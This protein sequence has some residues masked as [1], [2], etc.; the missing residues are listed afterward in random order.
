MIRNDL[1]EKLG[2]DWRSKFSHRD[3]DQANYEFG[4]FE[5]DGKKINLVLNPK[6]L[7]IMDYYYD[8]FSGKI[9]INEFIKTEKSKYE[10]KYTKYFIDKDYNIFT[11]DSRKNTINKRNLLNIKRHIRNSYAQLTIIT[12]SETSSDDR[13]ITNVLVHRIIANMFVP[14][15]D[16]EHFNIVNHK[17][18]NGDD[19]RKENLEWCSYSYNNSAENKQEITPRCYYLRSDGE[20]FDRKKLLDNNLCVRDVVYS[21]K[22]GRKY[23]GYTWSRVVPTLNNYLEKHPVVVDGWYEDNGL[24]DF[25]SHKVRANLCGILEID[26]I[27]NIGTLNKKTLIY[28]ITINKKHYF[29]HRL[30][31]EIISGK[32]IDKN[33]VIDHLIP[34]T[35]DN[36]DNSFYNL[37]EKTQSENMRNPLTQLLTKKYFNIDQYNIFGKLENSYRSITIEFIKNILEDNPSKFIKSLEKGCPQ[38]KNKIYLDPTKS[39]KLEDKVKYIFYRWKIDDKGNKVCE[40]GSRYFR[41]IV[42]EDWW[43]LEKYKLLKKYINTGVKAPDGYYYQQGT[44]DEIIYNPD[45]IELQ[46]VREIL[47]WS[48]N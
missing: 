25:G 22:N 32:L 48:R 7:D 15:P 31:Y 20:L 3:C 2:E 33:K 18:Y 13:E 23:K 44:P 1:K 45:N 9:S 40:A 4:E 43:E 6:T 27:L 19:N 36:I 37:S 38:F 30:V 14:N 11:E 35:S 46:K 17:N 29:I 42:S 5:V 24:H 10:N 8:D 41:N 47:I 34:V 16:P 28:Q 26:G 12:S 21:I 39:I